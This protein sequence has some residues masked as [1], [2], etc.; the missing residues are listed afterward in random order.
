MNPILLAGILR[1]FYDDFSMSKF[2]DRLKLQKMIYLLKSKD[3]NL[4]YPF[5]LYLYGPYS[6]ELTKDGFQ[7]MDLIKFSDT[8]KIAPSELKEDF[9]KFVKYIKENNLHLNDESLEIIASYLYI[10]NN[11]KDLS[12]KQIIE[13]MV[14]KRNKNKLNLNRIKEVI[15]NEKEKA[16][17]I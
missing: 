10:K 7:M 11:F 2:S 17:F 12:E 6:K 4:G 8:S 9:L 15:K 14:N 1:N 5:R 13:L 16:Y 3:I